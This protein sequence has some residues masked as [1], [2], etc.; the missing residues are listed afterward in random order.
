MLPYFTLFDERMEKDLLASWCL[1][2]LF[3]LLCAD[4]E[5]LY[6]SLSSDKKKAPFEKTE[7]WREEERLTEI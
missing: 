6:K 2:V 1:D 3:S 4:T 7:A 5:I